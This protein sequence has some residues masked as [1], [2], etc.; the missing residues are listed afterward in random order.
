MFPLRAIVKWANP[1]SVAGV[2]CVVT[3][4]SP[5][6]GRAS[7]GSLAEAVGLDPHP[8]GIFEAG[9]QGSTPSNPHPTNG[10]D[11]PALNLGVWRWGGLW[12]LPSAKGAPPSP[13]VSAYMTCVLVFGF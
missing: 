8:F 11:D 2:W 5:G 9:G 13:A 10:A 1:D 12:A 7:Q 3:S 4:T 6:I